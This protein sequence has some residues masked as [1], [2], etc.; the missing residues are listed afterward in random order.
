MTHHRDEGV[1]R[2][3]QF[4]ALCAFVVFGLGFACG[5]VLGYAA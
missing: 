1:S 4:I 5:F 2:F 3:F